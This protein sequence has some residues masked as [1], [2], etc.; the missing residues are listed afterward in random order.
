MV[1]DGKYWGPDGAIAA[2]EV[3]FAESD[4]TAHDEVRLASVYY[5]AANR[6]FADVLAGRVCM[7]GKGIRYSRLAYKLAWA[8]YYYDATVT[9][10]DIDVM[11]SILARYG[12][13]FNKQSRGRRFILLAAAAERLSCGEAVAPHTL[14]FL[15]MH[16]VR[17]LKA[18]LGDSEVFE[19]EALA[20][21]TAR[22][23]DFNQASR[24]NRQIASLLPKNHLQRQRLLDESVALADR[25]GAT[26]QLIK[27]G[28][29]T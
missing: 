4:Y 10:D 11:C 29:K 5:S 8:D 28:V 19:L 15:K 3:E 1:W 24:V 2:A 22:A 7:I 14:A 27:M 23:G 21:D 26:D 9:I 12:G 20:A 6:A 17:L 16:H 25:A 13:R 18:V